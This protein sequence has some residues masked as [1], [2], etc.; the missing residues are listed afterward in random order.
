MVVACST[1]HSAH[2]VNCAN[3]CSYFYPCSKCHYLDYCTCPHDLPV[4]A[5]LGCRLIP[6]TLHKRIYRWRERK[7]DTKH[8]PATQP[9]S[10]CQQAS[11]WSSHKQR[12]MLDPAPLR[13]HVHCDKHS[14]FELRVS[15][16]F[17]QLFLFPFLS[18]FL[19][20]FLCL[21]TSSRCTSRSSDR[22]VRADATA[23]SL[24]AKHEHF[25]LQYADDHD[26]HSVLQTRQAT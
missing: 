23:A 9:H 17:Y 16:S 13:L 2:E 21:S 15:A 6:A 18:L 19:F 1:C 26:H 24:M 10:G 12:R 22:K 11:P 8:L 14:V 4:A 7:R 3:L 25:T 20:L 5:Q